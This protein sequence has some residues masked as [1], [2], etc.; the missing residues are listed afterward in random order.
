MRLFKRA[1]TVTIG[2]AQSD[3][4]DLTFKIER[5]TRG[6][7]GV[8]TIT[9]RNPGQDMIAAAV[10]GA[11]V[12]LSAGYVDTPSP[13]LFSGVLRSA[14][15]AHPR[16]ER[17][18][19]VQARDVGGTYAEG[20]ILSR[21]YPADTAV[22]SIVSDAVAALGLGIGNLPNLTLTLRA[23]SST[24]PAAMAIHAP[25]RR[26]LSDM[27][28]GCGYRWSVQHGA[29]LALPRGRAGTSRGVSL[30]ASSGLLEP[31]TWDARHRVL[32]AR[33][34]IQPGLEPGRRVRVESET[35]RGDFEVRACTWVGDTAGADWYVE[36]E[37]GAL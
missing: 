24:I 31:P 26:V 37:L 30:S 29:V 35:A 33:A 18:L 32:T 23:G 10:D 3:G 21:T 9:I 7:A 28:G 17:T 12:R 2:T 34:Q 36:M 25:A 20:A 4:L 6:A 27:L 11:I 16:P 5:K 8:A 13:M 15:V 1:W 22:S 14:V 19:E